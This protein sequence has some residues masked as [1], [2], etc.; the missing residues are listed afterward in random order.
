M[1]PE[2]GMTTDQIQIIV[3]LF[4]EGAGRGCSPQIPA[5]T[6]MRRCVNFDEKDTFVLDLMRFVFIFRF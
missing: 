3:Y 1:L 2:H 4:F 5:C 6:F